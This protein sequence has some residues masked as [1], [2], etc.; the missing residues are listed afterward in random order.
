[1][2]IINILKKIV[3]P[4]YSGLKTGIAKTMSK[5]DEIVEQLKDVNTEI[6]L[7]ESLSN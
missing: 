7:M 1:M 5:F 6:I 3:E 4:L 2:E